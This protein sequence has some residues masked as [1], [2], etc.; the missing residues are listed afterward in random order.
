[1][2]EQV[3]TMEENPYVTMWTL[4]E[5][6][7]PIQGKR[8]LGHASCH[9]SDA[10]Y[11]HFHYLHREHKDFCDLL[12]QILSI[13]FSCFTPVAVSRSEGNMSKSCSW[14]ISKDLNSKAISSICFPRTQLSGL[15]EKAVLLWE[16]KLLGTL[17]SFLLRYD[18]EMEG[19]PELA[20][21]LFLCLWAIWG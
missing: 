8:V 2:F 18:E 21:L 13:R 14:W 15:W 6:L 5:Y 16:S 3:S 17:D 7:V 19:G 4:K 12:F 20:D 9:S 10:S 1:M 11:L